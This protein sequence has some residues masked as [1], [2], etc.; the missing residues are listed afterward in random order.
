[1]RTPC[2]ALFLVLTLAAAPPG[3]TQAKGFFGAGLQDAFTGTQVSALAP[4][5]PAARGGVQVGDGIVAINGA[6]AGDA[7]A[8]ARALSGVQAGQKVRLE[9]VRDGQHL[10]LSVL[11]GTPPAGGAQ[12]AVQGDTP[13]AAPI[14]SSVTTPAATANTTPPKSVAPVKVARYVVFTEP[15]EHAFTMEVPERW[16]IT[17]SQMRRA[18]LEFSPFVRALSPDKMT[19]LMVGEPTLLTYT[20]PNATTVRLGWREGSLHAAQQGGVTMLLRYIPGP[21]F[22]KLYGQTALAGLCPQLRFENAAERSDF[23]AATDK[24]IPTVIPSQSTGGQASFSCR[25]GGVDMAVTVDAVTRIDRNSIL[26]NVIFLRAFIT[27]KSQTEAAQEVLQH[28]TQSYRYDPAWVN[29]QQG[30]ERQAAQQIAARVQEA[31]RQEQG[32]IKNLNA[33][34]ENFTSIDD[35]VSGYSTYRNDATG[36]TYKLSNTNPGKYVNDGRIISTPDGNPPAWAPAAQKMTRV[37]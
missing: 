26:W 14:P 32:V 16:L 6:P 5:G 19:Y 34:D 29:L 12:A 8:T 2:A 13:S 17:G 28:M 25:H 21:K 35:I 7:A 22:A 23:V 37:D 20:P 10:T 3:F 27:P 18:A 11:M 9:L 1:M 36:D 15:T 33:T 30:I 31:E 4:G 24:L